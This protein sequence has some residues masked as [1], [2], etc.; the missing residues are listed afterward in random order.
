MQCIFYL[1]LVHT[2][3]V[4]VLYILFVISTKIEGVAFILLNDPIVE[5][6]PMITS[7]HKMYY[8]K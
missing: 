8:R 2:K 7:L 3:F 5:Q 1:C 4:V 6:D